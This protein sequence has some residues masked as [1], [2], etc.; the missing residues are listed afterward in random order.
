MVSQG[1]DGAAVMSGQ[2][3][4]VQKR[5]QDVAPSTICIH[6]YAHILNL[7][8]VDSVKN[9]QYCSEFLNLFESLY[10]FMSNSK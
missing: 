1:Y 6:C 5:I 2:C 7:A 4:G 3:S 8:L 9:V 10:V